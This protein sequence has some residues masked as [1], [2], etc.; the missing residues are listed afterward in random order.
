MTSPNFSRPYSISCFSKYLQIILFLLFISA[1]PNIPGNSYAEETFYSINLDSFIDVETATSRVKDLKGLGHNAFYR[2]ENLEEEGVYRVYIESYDSRSEAENEAAILKD[3]GLISG[4]TIQELEKIPGADSSL[5]KP[6]KRLYN[7]QVSS[8]KEKAHAENIVEN[9]KKSGCSAFYRLETVKDKGEWYRVYITGYESMGEAEKEARRLM[10]SGIISGY[11][12][13]RIETVN[14]DKEL[15][16][17]HVGSFKED[18]NAEQTARALKEKGFN[19]FYQTEKVAGEDWFRLYIG[20]FEDE[21]TARETGSELKEKGIISYY[22]SL[23]IKR[24]AIK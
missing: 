16:F 11:S 23:K 15:Y 2:Y 20:E 13:Q 21:K 8:L 14:Y 9:L 7:L 3:L 19:A 10:E 22:K 5:I 17:L 6:D 24:D 1:I 18:S 4:Y 12:S